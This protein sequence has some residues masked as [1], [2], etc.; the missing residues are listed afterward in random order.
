MKLYR[1][2]AVVLRTHDLGEADRIV[3]FLSR[4]HGRVR[5]VAKGV[6][7]TKSRFGARLE[8][9]AMI[10]VQL[11][12]GRTLDVVTEVS[13]L[14]AFGLTIGRDYDAFTAASAMAEIAERLTAEEGEPDEDQYLLLVGA[15]NSLASHAH[16]PAA[17]LDSYVLRAL[18]LSGWAVAIWNCARCG[19][20]GPHSAFHVQSGGMVCEDCVP[21]GAAHPSAATVELL[22]GLLAGDW[23][24]V[25]AAQPAVRKNAGSL[26]AAYLQ[27]HIERQIKSLRL[28]GSAD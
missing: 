8:P 25:D 23:G 24:V 17:T 14:N 1:D 20:P 2:E 3:T 6:R 4:T 21:R 19:A 7:R 27:W 13:T 22:G 12:E 11:Y 18:A 5:G 28:V 10:D 15:L 9:F 16:D 26:I